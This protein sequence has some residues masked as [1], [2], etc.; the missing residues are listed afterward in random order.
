MTANEKKQHSLWLPFNAWGRVIV[1]ASKRMGDLNLVLIAAGVAFYGLLSF[2]PTVTAGVALLGLVLDPAT[3]LEQSA[4]FLDIL[5]EGAEQIV[6]GQLQEVAGAEPTGLELAAL[7]SLAIALWSAS[8]AVG[9]VIQGLNV[10]YE[11]DEKR[12]YV[13]VKALTIALTIFIV[14]GLAVTI[15]LIAAVPAALAIVGS[16]ASS[17]ALMVR[18]PLMF[19]V[20]VFGITFLYRFGPSRPNSRWHLVTPGAFIACA[21]WVAGTYGFSYYVQSFGNYNE[22][23]GTLAGVIV[24]LTWMWISALILL[25]GALLDAEIG[26]Q[27]RKHSRTADP[28]LAS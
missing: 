13:T 26:F 1:R 15:T 27:H 4:W 7:L 20:G 3:L 8:A 25:I 18:W 21:F 2:F 23:F 19:M 10:I 17:I 28:K 12:G 5:P 16:E 22:T 6:V 24:L 11:E 9:G 14:F